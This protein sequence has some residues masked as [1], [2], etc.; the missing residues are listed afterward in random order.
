MRLT[1][2]QVKELHELGKTQR[3]AIPTPRATTDAEWA[4][5]VPRMRT[6]GNAT[7]CE[8]LE[9]HERCVEPR[10]DLTPCQKRARRR[11]VLDAWREVQKRN[12]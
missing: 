4:V 9:A 7:I 5:E 12:A 10:G 3:A 2:Q 11:M 1:P 6:S 8:L